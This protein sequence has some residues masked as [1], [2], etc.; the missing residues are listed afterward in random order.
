MPIWSVPKSLD[1]GAGGIRGPSGCG[2]QSHGSEGWTRGARSSLVKRGKGGVERS[3]HGEGIATGAPSIRA[4]R[5]RSSMKRDMR[6]CSAASASSASWDS[7]LGSSEDGSPSTWR[8]SRACIRAA[9]DGMS[10]RR[11]VR[12]LRML[13]RP[14]E[15]SLSPG[16][17][18]I[19]LSGGVLNNLWANQC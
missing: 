12:C 6:P 18:D 9:R 2:F 5:R 19:P 14:F 4:R 13:D 3:A 17:G 10:A 8:I 1:S 16:L 11:M 7:W 15:A